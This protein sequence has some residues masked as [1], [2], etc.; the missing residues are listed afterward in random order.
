MTKVKQAFT[1]SSDPSRYNISGHAD[2][3]PEGYDPANDD[4]GYMNPD[5]LAYFWQKMFLEREEL[6]RKVNNIR[7]EV[8]QPISGSEEADRASAEIFYASTEIQM[9]SDIEKARKLTRAIDDIE[10]NGEDAQYGHSVISGKE[11]GVGRL[12]ALP[13]ATFTIK[14]QQEIEQLTPS[15][16]M[17]RNAA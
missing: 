5:M 3:L 6:K 11:I 1:K 10:K 2:N 15:S 13:T 7:K 4:N 8:A 14:E 17:Q 12:K 16:S 9:K